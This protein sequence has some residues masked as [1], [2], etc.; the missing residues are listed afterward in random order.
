MN[1]E[2]ELMNAV[3]H[4]FIKYLKHNPRSPEKLKPVHK[5]FSKFVHNINNSFQINSISY[6]KKNKEDKLKGNFYEKTVDISVKNKNNEII[7]ACALKFYHFK[8]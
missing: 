4:S 5:F 2:K 8:L 3:K 7:G 1:D 6:G